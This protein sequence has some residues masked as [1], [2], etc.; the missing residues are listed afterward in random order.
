MDKE[1][2][3]NYIN[4]ML[5]V[6]K[7]G[8]EL[9]LFGTPEYD[10]QGEFIGIKLFLAEHKAKIYICPMYTTNTNFLV[11]SFQTIKSQKEE[12]KSLIE[13]EVFGE[14]CCYIDLPDEEYEAK[15]QIVKNT[16]TKIYKEKWLD[17]IFNQITDRIKNMSF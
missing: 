13:K 10:K 12:I 17:N 1:I 3:G 7:I 6:N 9:D 15:E 11:L 16:D 14:D 2:I 8:L 4:K 5:E